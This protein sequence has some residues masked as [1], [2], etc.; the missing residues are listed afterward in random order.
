MAE[1][2][3]HLAV[4]AAGDVAGGQAEDAA[5]WLGVEQHEAGGGA[6]PDGRVV[7]GEVAAQQG[8]AAVLGDRFAFGEAELRELAG[9]DMPGGHGP[10]QETAGAL[11]LVNG[12]GGVPGVDIGLGEVRRAGGRVRAV[13]DRKFWAWM[14]RCS[15][16]L[17]A[18]G[19]SGAVAAL[20]RM[21]GSWC[22]R[23][24]W[25]SS[26]SCGW[27]ARPARRRWTQPS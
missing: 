12:G 6:D 17:R 8:E 2:D 10:G 27:P 9:G 1:A 20:A 13:Q 25:R 15:A 26:R 4:V 3:V 19:R 24:N 23:L 18:L 11:L 5:E 21:R 16:Y 7:V 14:N 22:Q